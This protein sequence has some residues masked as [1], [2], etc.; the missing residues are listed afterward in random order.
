[1]SLHAQIQHTPEHKL[2]HD[3][4]RTFLDEYHAELRKVQAV[5]QECREKRVVV[6]TLLL[7]ELE[8]RGFNAEQREAALW[9]FRNS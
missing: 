8:L 9:A 3:S 6:M 2:S 7:K 5:E 4:L 1:M